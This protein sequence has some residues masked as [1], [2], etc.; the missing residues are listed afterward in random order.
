MVIHLCKTIALVVSCGCIGQIN[1]FV[2]LKHIIL[3]INDTMY[4]II[5][6]IYNI[7]CTICHNLVD[8]MPRRVANIL[9]MK[10]FATKY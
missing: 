8:F 7:P 1:D 10:E 6:N 3:M 5:Y 4:N 9:K 2:V